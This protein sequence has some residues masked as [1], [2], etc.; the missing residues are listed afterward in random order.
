[1]IKNIDIP[2]T[3]FAKKAVHYNGVSIYSYVVMGGSSVFSLVAGFRQNSGYTLESL[4]ILISKTCTLEIIGEQFS[5]L[6]NI[7]I[8]V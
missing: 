1:M 7:P 6:F 5:L 4:A 3:L 8:C 2:Q